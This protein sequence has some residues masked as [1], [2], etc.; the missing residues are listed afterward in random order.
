MT[1]QIFSLLIIIMIAAV[2]FGHRD[3]AWGDPMMVCRDKEPAEKVMQM[4]RTGVMT[5]GESEV[6]CDNMALGSSVHY[7]YVC[8]IITRDWASPSP[9]AHVSR[10]WT[11]TSGDFKKLLFDQ[12]FSDDAARCHLICGRCSTSWQPTR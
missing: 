3:G 10:V 7:R 11:C 5:D 8:R 2:L 1:S 6:I 12:D 9:Y 4:C